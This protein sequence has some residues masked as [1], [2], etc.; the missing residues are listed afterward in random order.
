MH[1]KIE[2]LS[3]VEG[4]DHS[5][6]VDFLKTLIQIFMGEGIALFGAFAA[7]LNLRRSGLMM[8]TNQVNE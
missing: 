5:K 1:D 3:N 8:G 6:P 4:R 7:M 2:V